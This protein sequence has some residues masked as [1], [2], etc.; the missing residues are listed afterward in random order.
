MDEHG[1]GNIVCFL[2][3]KFQV[4][5]VFLGQTFFSEWMWFLIQEN[6]INLSWG[7]NLK[8]YKSR[9]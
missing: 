5:E 9:S 6:L 7:E 3:S 8:A 2:G 4:N 1:S